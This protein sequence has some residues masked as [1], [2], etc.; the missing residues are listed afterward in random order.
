M[1]EAQDSGISGEDAE[2]EHRDKVDEEERVGALQ[3]GAAELREQHREEDERQA[4]QQ[5]AEQRVAPAVQPGGHAQSS[6]AN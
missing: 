6:S 4:E 3:A 5:S 1:A 2:A